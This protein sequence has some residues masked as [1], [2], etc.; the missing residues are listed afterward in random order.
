MWK[1]FSIG[2][3]FCS[4]FQRSSWSW[5]F[6]FNWRRS[7]CCWPSSCSSCCPSSSRSPCCC[8]WCC[9]CSCWFPWLGSCIFSSIIKP[10]GKLGTI[11]KSINYLVYFYKDINR[12]LNL[13]DVL[14][15]YFL[16]GSK[17]QK[18]RFKYIF[19]SSHLD[20]I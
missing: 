12:V 5:I 13:A 14:M 9:T 10:S 17:T 6:I 18:R 3:T 16:K 8:S 1:C 7:G 19:N 4:I 11:F 2:F 15:E 20:Q